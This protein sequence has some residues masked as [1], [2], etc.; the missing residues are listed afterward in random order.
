MSPIL[1]NSKG[2]KFALR[3]LNLIQINLFLEAVEQQ[4]PDCLW[5]QTHELITMAQLCTAVRELLRQLFCA[6]RSG[7]S[8]TVC[9]PLRWVNLSLPDVWIQ[10]HGQCWVFINQ[11][12]YNCQEKRDGAQAYYL[13]KSSDFYCDSSQFPWRPRDLFWLGNGPDLGNESCVWGP[14]YLLSYTNSLV[15]NHCSFWNGSPDKDCFF[16]GCRLKVLDGENGHKKIVTSPR[17]S[18]RRGISQV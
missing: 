8:Y 2:R 13:D 3:L 10:W 15:L 6:G 11:S 16:V 4:Y 5:Q 14:G 9:H 1:G 17:E 18:R 7:Y 12:Q